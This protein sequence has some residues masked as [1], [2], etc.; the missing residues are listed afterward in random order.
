MESKLHHALPSLNV[1]RKL[2]YTSY[3]YTFVELYI[4][5][6]DF[7]P[8]QIVYT[9]NNKKI[10]TREIFP[11]NLALTSK[12]LLYTEKCFYIVGTTPPAAL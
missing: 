10:P 8:L 4:F 9:E 2:H 6:T 3:S 12:Q 7:T 11:G 5:H 1:L